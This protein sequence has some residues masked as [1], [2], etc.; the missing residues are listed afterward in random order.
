MLKREDD[1]TVE[2]ILFFYVQQNDD[3][4]GTL[5]YDKKNIEVILEKNI[6]TDEFDNAIEGFGIMM[7]NFKGFIEN[8]LEKSSAKIN[9]FAKEWTEEKV[10]A[11]IIADRIGKNDF[12]IVIR[13]QRFEIYFDDDFLF[14]GAKVYYRG[15]FDEDK[16]EVDILT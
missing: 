8:V 5:T 13:N 9:T 7:E 15:S 2:G 3:Y 10:N 4:A 16:F 12:S 1:I 6:K 11:E 14:Y